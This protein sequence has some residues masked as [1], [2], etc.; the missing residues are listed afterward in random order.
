MAAREVG[1]AISCDRGLGGGAA[2]GTRRAAQNEAPCP[3]QLES[4][5]EA[6]PKQTATCWRAASSILHTEVHLALAANF[7]AAANLAATAAA[8]LA[9]AAAVAAV[10]LAALATTLAALVVAP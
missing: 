6:P 3:K 2:C 1:R 7:V 10:G 8:A 9:L 4:P 5:A